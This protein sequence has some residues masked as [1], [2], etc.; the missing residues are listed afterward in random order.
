VDRFPVARDILICALERAV[1]R[2]ELC[3]EAGCPFWEPGGAVLS[4]RCA[5]ERLD[6]SSRPEVARELL[7]VREL[8]EPPASASA[9][10]EARHLFHHLLNESE[11]E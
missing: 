6:L 1:G 3:P 7:H 11:D 10:S 2:H 8:L 4:G 5:F 9:Q